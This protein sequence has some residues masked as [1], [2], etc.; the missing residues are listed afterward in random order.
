MRSSQ[1]MSGLGSGN[2]SC[3]WDRFWPGL[4]QTGKQKGCR[5]NAA[6]GIDSAAT[7]CQQ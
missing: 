7:S 1:Q 2:W 5:R 3:R 6:R 4:A